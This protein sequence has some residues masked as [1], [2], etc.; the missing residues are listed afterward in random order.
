MP[1]ILTLLIQVAHTLRTYSFEM[2][3]VHGLSLSSLGIPHD[4]FPRVLQ[5][6]LNKVMFEAFQTPQPSLPDG[7]ILF[8]KGRAKMHFVEA[9]LPSSHTLLPVVVPNLVALKCLT[10]GCL[11]LDTA[12]MRLFYSRK[13]NR[14]FHFAMPTG[15]LLNV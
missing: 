14:L 1:G 2:Y 5:H 11:S 7:V 8:L 10:I 9:A 6:S 3:K 15:T 4:V 12:W 13:G